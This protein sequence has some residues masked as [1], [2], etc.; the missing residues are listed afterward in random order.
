M[1]LRSRLRRF[2]LPGLLLLGVGIVVLRIGFVKA[3]TVPSPTIIEP[4][5]PE[6]QVRGE[7]VFI[8]PSSLQRREGYWLM[9]HA[10]SPEEIGAAHARMG[11]WLNQRAETDMFESL[12]LHVPAPLRPLLFG[13]I[14]WQYRHM[15]TQIPE[16]MLRELQAFARAYQDRWAGFLPIYQRAIYYH[17]LHDITQELVGSPLVMAC[18]SFAASGEATVNGH[19]LIGR[20]FDFEVFPIFDEEKVVHLFAPDGKIPFASVSWTGLAGVVT[21]MNAEGIFL[22]VNAAWSEGYN[23][24]GPPVSLLARQVLE[25]AHSL[26]EAVEI[27]RANRTMVSDIYTLG[28]G[29][30]GEAVIVERGVEKFATRPMVGGVVA[31]TNHMLTDEFKEDSRDAALMNVSTTLARYQRL[32]ELLDRHRGFLSPLSVLQILRDRKGRGDRE[33][34]PGNRNALDALIATHS[35]IAD[36]TTRTLWVSTWPH[37]LNPFRRIDLLA[38]F[39]A[40]GV[41]V[42]PYQRAA[43]PSLLVPASPSPQGEV[44]PVPEGDF[45]ADPFLNEGGFEKWKRLR[46]Y[47][48][49]GRNYLEEGAFAEALHMVETANGLFSSD[50]DVLLLKGDTLEK[51]GR[52]EEARVAWRQY[53]EGDPPRCKEFLEVRKKLGL[54]EDDLAR[55][56]ASTAKA[57]EE[58][59]KAKKK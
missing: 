4:S 50:P 55:R 38:E 41:D 27:L 6:T 1:S 8:G 43:A 5:L 13:V 49:E 34:T 19:L 26:S 46:L 35:V 53:L 24:V 40:M 30:T 33:L 15:H 39:A 9:T 21:G 47:V 45:P 12:R 11:D 52:L 51:A 7:D 32:T 16:R 3:T 28:D 56:A 57:H 22:S 59:E 20:N 58:A 23:R 31:A 36:A 2:L 44:T 42:T 54:P 10:G 18:S 37:L 17:T 25:E 48:K 14:K 29:E